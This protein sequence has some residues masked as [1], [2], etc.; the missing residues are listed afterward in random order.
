MAMYTLMCG[1]I[2]CRGSSYSDPNRLRTTELV[3][4]DVFFISNITIA[5][6]V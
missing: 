3:E 4:F 5:L 6:F 2:A 1:Y